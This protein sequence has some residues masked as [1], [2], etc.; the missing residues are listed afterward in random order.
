MRTALRAAQARRLPCGHALTGEQIDARHV[1]ED[2]LRAVAIETDLELARGPVR[3]VLEVVALAG[4]E[5]RAV[6]GDVERRPVRDP[7]VGRAVLVRAP[8]HAVGPAVAVIVVVGRGTVV[9]RDR[10]GNAAHDLADREQVARRRRGRIGL[11]GFLA[12]PVDAVVADRVGPPA[13]EPVR[14]AVRPTA[15]AAFGPHEQVARKARAL[16]AHLRAIEHRRSMRALEA[17]ESDAVRDPPARLAF[18]AAVAHAAASVLPPDAHLAEARAR[19]AEV[20]AGLRVRDALALFHAAALRIVDART[21]A[22]DADE[23]QPSREIHPSPFA[24]PRSRR[25]APARLASRHSPSP[26][27]QP[28]R[29]FT[30]RARFLG[31]QRYRPSVA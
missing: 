21:D 28:G 15:R 27:P 2:H 31:G 29:R 4:D 19:V 12:A 20:G 9:L 24:A 14:A 25:D 23:T 8:L 1:S 18:A 16:V 3:V 6:A 10:I 7:D 13:P 26:L 22:H 30:D 17:A 5:H 11:R